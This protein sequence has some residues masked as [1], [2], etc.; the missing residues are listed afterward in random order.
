M[1][2]CPRRRRGL[3]GSGCRL[4][5]RRGRVAGGPLP[6]P[7]TPRGGL[8][9]RHCRSS[10]KKL[11][12]VVHDFVEG[13]DTYTEKP[14]YTWDAAVAFADV[15]P[16]DYAALVIP[17]GRAPE[18]I[19]NDPDCRRIVEHFF[20]VDKPVA[21]LCHAS[22]VLAAAGMWQPAPRRGRRR[23]RAGPLGHGSH[24]RDR[25]RRADRGSRARRHQRRAL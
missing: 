17:G 14:G 12:F 23:N 16:N 20:G 5:R 1:P 6:L 7:A 11:Q 25:P 22:L 3:C 9:R 15:D 21:Q 13:F 2:G 4:R 10:K 18:Y 24:P 8:R 19:R